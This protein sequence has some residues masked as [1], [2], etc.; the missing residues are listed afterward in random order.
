MLWPDL[1]SFRSR[2]RSWCA[3]LP[4]RRCARWTCGSRHGGP[5]PA[6]RRPP[7]QTRSSPDRGSAT[8]VE[9][10]QAPRESPGAR[11]PRAPRC[12]DAERGSTAPRPTSLA[13]RSPHAAA[14]RGRADRARSRLA[15]AGPGGLI[16]R[17]ALL[18]T[19]GPMRFRLRP[20]AMAAACATCLLGAEPRAVAGRLLMRKPVIDFFEDR[21]K[22]IR[23]SWRTPRSR[24]PTPSATRS[25]SGA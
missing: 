2:S 19:A 16:G 18:T 10:E 20:R 7:A 8:R 25:G 14:R 21:R 3:V 9:A 24:E 15:G 1:R 6:P 12:A 5:G 17:S 13:R 22:R 11:P 23:P 4:A